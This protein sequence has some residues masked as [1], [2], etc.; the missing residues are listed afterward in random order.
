MVKWITSFSFLFAFNFLTAQTTVGLTAYFSFND[1]TADESTGNNSI[2]GVIS[3][4]PTCECGVN[5]Q[6]LRFNGSSDYVVVGGSVNGEFDTEDFTVSFFFKPLGGA[7]VRTL[8]AKTGADCS[9]QNVF[10]IRYD[11]GTKLL[12][13]Q[14]IENSSKNG[15][16]TRVPVPTENCWTHLVVVRRSN[17]TILYLNGEYVT[18][19]STTNRVNVRNDGNLTIAQSYCPNT[20]RNFEGLLDEIRIYNRAL[21]E[22]EIAELYLPIDKILT[23]DT[24]IFLGESVNVEI[25]NTCV[26]QFSWAPV[27]GVDDIKEPEATLTPSETTTYTLS[28]LESGCVATDTIRIV[29]IDP[30]TLSCEKLFLPKAFTPNGDNLNERYG[31]SNPEVFSFG[32]GELISFEIF[33]RWGSLIFYTEDAREKGDGTFKSKL[34]NPGVLLYKVRYK[35]N[36]EEKT[37]AGSLTLLK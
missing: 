34:V 20:D 37:E 5:G 1:C 14:L 24:R 15:S 27:V 28:F 21:R 4:S 3:G 11:A 7:G 12:N 36:G 22:E 16:I 30:T 13:I 32:S 25:S 8:M 17:R 26:S 31:I 35:C 9:D 6:A 18:E 2:L 10:A 23:E 29:V 19:A 33:D